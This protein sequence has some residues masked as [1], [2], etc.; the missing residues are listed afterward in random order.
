[1]KKVIRLTESELT[2]LI[3]KVIKEGEPKCPDPKNIDTYPGARLVKGQQG[4]F[5]KLFKANLKVDGRYGPKTSVY[6]KKYIESK[7]MTP[8]VGTKEYAGPYAGLISDM[9][10]GDYELANKL[11]NFMVE[12]GLKNYVPNVPPG[13][14]R[15]DFDK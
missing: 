11:F 6:M 3:K 15:F 4:L 13:C 2:N 14:E 1:M 8:V 5:N 10:N 12:D 7:G 9:F